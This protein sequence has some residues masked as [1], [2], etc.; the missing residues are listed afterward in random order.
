MFTARLLLGRSGL[1]SRPQSTPRQQ[2]SDESKHCPYSEFSKRALHFSISHPPTH[3]VSPHPTYTCNRVRARSHISIQPSVVP[4]LHS[5]RYRNNPYSRW[6]SHGFTSLIWTGELKRFFISSTTFQLENIAGLPERPPQIFTTRFKLL[7]SYH[8]RGCDKTC[9]HHSVAEDLFKS[10]AAQ[11][12]LTTSTSRSRSRSQ[13]HIRL[14]NTTFTP[15]A[16]Q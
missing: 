8:K 1:S 12:D 13:S 7:C 16:Q 15:K 11:R 5:V 14:G 3:N 10:R 2:S 4:P 6:A 9:R